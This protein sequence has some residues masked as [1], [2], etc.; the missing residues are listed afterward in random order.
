VESRVVD[1]LLASPHPENIRFLG[2]QNAALDRIVNR[3]ESMADYVVLDLGL[4]GC[5]PF[6]TCS[7]VPKN[8]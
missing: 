8:A 2:E 6:W 4:F 1:M 5:Q 7:N 3:L